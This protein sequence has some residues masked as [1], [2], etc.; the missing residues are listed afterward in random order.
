MAQ[1][2]LNPNL[3]IF[4]S[5]CKYLLTGY[6]ITGICLTVPLLLI[7]YLFFFCQISVGFYLFLFLCISWYLVFF[8]GDRTGLATRVTDCV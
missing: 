2:V 4:G 6:F 1:I 8:G 3:L 5:F 7:F